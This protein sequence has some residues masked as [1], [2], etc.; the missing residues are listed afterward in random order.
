MWTA[1]SYTRRPVTRSDPPHKNPIDTCPTISKQTVRLDRRQRSTR[2]SLPDRLDR[3][4][5]RVIQSPDWTVP[6]D[7]K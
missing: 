3:L 2:F 5:V 7:P 6:V 4:S 1:Q